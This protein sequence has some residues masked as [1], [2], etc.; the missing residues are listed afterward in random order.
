MTLSGTASFGPSRAV[1]HSRI[2]YASPSRGQVSIDDPSREALTAMSGSSG[3]GAD[4]AIWV[5][6][7][8]GC[9]R[10][11]L[12]PCPGDAGFGASVVR[13]ADVE[14]LADDFSGA[15]VQS[16]SND[17]EMLERAD[18]WGSIGRMTVL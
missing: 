1:V 16:S 8:S 17:V 12:H 2:R 7:Y 18:V 5:R 15:V 14:G 11:M 10:G 9:G 3:Q 6:Q 4:A 13:D